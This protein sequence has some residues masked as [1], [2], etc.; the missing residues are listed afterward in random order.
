MSFKTHKLRDAIAIALAVGVAAPGLALAQSNEESDSKTLDRIEVTGSRIKRAEVEG[1]LPVTVI[2]REQL[3]TSGDISV[4][5]YLRNTSFNTFG[6]FQSTSGSSGQGFTGIS[7]RGLG[8][9]RTL[10]LI[11]GRRA[12]TAPMIGNSQDLNSIPM[13]AVERIELLSDGASAIYGSDAIGGV[14]NVITRKDFEG[15]EASVGL[16]M[17]SSRVSAAT[18]RA[19]RYPPPPMPGP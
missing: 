6:S 8:T 13:A 4:A 18:P 12:P 16:G 11:D 2:G 10:I 19:R 9:N 1:A 14:V 5:D 17:P 3:E 7:L 15:I